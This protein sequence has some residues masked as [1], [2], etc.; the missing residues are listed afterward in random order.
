VEDSEDAQQ[1]PIHKLQTVISKYG[2]KT[3]KSKTKTMEI[4]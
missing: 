1:I 2:L 3:S 4:Q